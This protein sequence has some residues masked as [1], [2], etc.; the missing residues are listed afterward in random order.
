[1]SSTY[2]TAQGDAWDLIAKKFY[3]DERQMH[4]LIE[5][6]PTHRGVLLFSAGVVLTVPEVDT[7]QVSALP[8]WRQ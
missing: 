6:N 5:A 7:A 3:G 2:T 4:R 8:P 1:M